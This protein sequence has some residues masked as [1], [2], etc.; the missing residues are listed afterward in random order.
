MG[1]LGFDS[2]L[3]TEGSVMRGLGVTSL[4]IV[5]VP[6]TGYLRHFSD[7]INTSVRTVEAADTQQRWCPVDIFLCWSQACGKAGIFVFINIAL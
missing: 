2:I 5:V 3:V 7:V 1:S 6:P 4:V